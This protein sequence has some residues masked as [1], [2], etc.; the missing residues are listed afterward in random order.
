MSKQMPF[1]WHGGED[2]DSPGMADVSISYDKKVASFR[3][4]HLNSDG[5][6]FCLLLCDIE[7]KEIEKLLK[8]LKEAEGDDGRS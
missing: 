2:Y 7:V 3:F 5:S 4:A 8:T 6:D 1:K